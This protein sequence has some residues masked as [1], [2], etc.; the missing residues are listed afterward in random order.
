MFLK[1]RKPEDIKWFNEAKEAL[2]LERL[3]NLVYNW[4]LADPVNVIPTDFASE[5]M[6][7]K[8]EAKKAK[9]S[10]LKINGAVL[11]GAYKADR[12]FNNEL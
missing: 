12:L 10:D 2:L 8:A 1:V 9:I 11:A 3:E 6:Q 4:R 5:F 7:L